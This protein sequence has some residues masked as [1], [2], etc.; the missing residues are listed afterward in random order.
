MFEALTVVRI[1]DVVMGTAPPGLPAAEAEAEETTLG[2]PV[3]AT[4]PAP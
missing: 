2:A 4:T 1:G 3:F